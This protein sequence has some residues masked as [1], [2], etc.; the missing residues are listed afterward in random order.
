[1]TLSPGASPRWSLAPTRTV[2][3]SRG[4]ATT[5]RKHGELTVDWAIYFNAL[6]DEDPVEVDS[7]D[8]DMLA[9]PVVQRSTQ[10]YD[11]CYHEYDDTCT[12]KVVLD[13]IRR[14][15]RDLFLRA[16]TSRLP[17]SGTTEEALITRL[18]WYGHHQPDT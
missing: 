14:H 16:E 8:R 18:W 13:T 9:K 3:R 7:V 2:T 5:G 11:W 4:D 15:H 12:E 6:V 10:L 1:M 17:A